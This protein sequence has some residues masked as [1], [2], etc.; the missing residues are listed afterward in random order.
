MPQMRGKETGPDH[1]GLSG[2]DLKEKLTIL[3]GSGEAKASRPPLHPSSSICLAIA[4]V[5]SLQ[6]L[7]AIILLQRFVKGASDTQ[8][9]FPRHVGVDH[10]G[11]KILLAQQQ[12]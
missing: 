4:E 10:R 7:R 3:Y 12:R 1:F 11:L 8:D 9:V 5:F 2:K 6:I